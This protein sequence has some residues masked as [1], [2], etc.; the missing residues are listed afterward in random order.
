MI[1]IN[2]IIV[3]AEDQELPPAGVTFH[4]H[5]ALGKASIATDGEIADYRL[6]LKASNGVTDVQELTTDD[7]IGRVLGE[8]KDRLEL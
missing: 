1:D 8:L 2:G 5:S 7:D 6:Y 4:W 3:E